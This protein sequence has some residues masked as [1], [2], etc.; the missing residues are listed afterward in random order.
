MARRS[1]PQCWRN[2]EVVR[3]CW[4]AGLR[5]PEVN[6]STSATCGQCTALGFQRI[7]EVREHGARS[8]G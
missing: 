5:F 6:A 3:R 1:N 4:V 7:L 8:R 2:D